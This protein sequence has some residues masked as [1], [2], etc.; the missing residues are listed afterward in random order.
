LGSVAGRLEH[1]LDVGPLG[2]THNNGSIARNRQQTSAV[3]GRVRQILCRSIDLG[4]LKLSEPGEEASP[5][6]GKAW[7]LHVKSV[8]LSLDGCLFDATLASAV[9]ALATLRFPR[10][11]EQLGEDAAGEDGGRPEGDGALRFLWVPACTAVA[12]HKGRLLV[13][14]TDFEESL[15][16]AVVAVVWG[17]RADSPGGEEPEVLALELGSEGQRASVDAQLV[18]RCL[19]VCGGRGTSQRLAALASLLVEDIDGGEADGMMEA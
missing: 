17:R 11:L 8:C 3:S 2:T 4:S 12:L 19:G 13:D 5:G 18:R 14:P 15:A 10:R 7:A 9:A 16:S 1:E 6:G